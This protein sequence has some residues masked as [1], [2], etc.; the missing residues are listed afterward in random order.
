MRQLTHTCNVP[1]TERNAHRP[2]QCALQMTIRVGWANFRSALQ[3]GV[4]HALHG[5]CSHHQRA[6]SM[7]YT[8]VL[9]LQWTLQLTGISTI[10]G[11]VTATPVYGS[12]RGKKTACSLDDYL[13][14]N[15][16]V[17]LTCNSSFDRGAVSVAPAACAPMRTTPL[18]ICTTVARQLPLSDEHFE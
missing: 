2:A 8:Q 1:C 3:C 16:S 11:C 4:D 15:N 17:S 14:P 9:C 10:S 13:A 6:S 7:S 12:P 18:F 5:M